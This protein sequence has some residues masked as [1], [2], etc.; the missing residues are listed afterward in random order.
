MSIGLAIISKNEEDNLPTLLASID[1]CFDRVVLLDTGSEDATVPR[2]LAW[3]TDQA[4]DHPGFT[5]SIDSFEWTDDFSEARTAADKLLLGSGGNAVDW[6]C[7]ADCDDTIRGAD[8][9]R[10]IADQAPAEVAALIFGYDYAQDPG[11]G[12]TVCHLR[13]ERL[14]RAGAG[15]WGGRVHEAQTVA[16]GVQLVPD[17]IVQWIHGKQLDAE[18]VGQ[19]NTR[20]LT[21]LSEWVKD[22]PT[23]QRVLAYM[24]KELAARNEHEDALTYYQRYMA[25]PP[26]WSDERAQVYRLY[27]R[28]L[29]AL[30]RPLEE[31]EQLAAEALMFHPM[32]PDSWLTLAEIALAREQHDKGQ[33]YAE[34]VIGQ[35]GVALRSMLIV[36]PLDYTAYPLRLI[37][38][39]HGAAGRTDEAIRYAEQ[40]LSVNPGD[41]F[42]RGWWGAWKAE[43][44]RNHT[45]DT[46]AMCAEQLIAHDEQLKAKTL[47]E[48]CVPYF[49]VDHPRIVQLRQF[50]RRRLS[51]VDD[52]T[53]F[54]DHYE[55]GG[56]KPEDFHSDEQ[57]DE[58]AQALPRTH[59][60]I[61]NLKEQ[62]A[63]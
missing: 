6:T 25:E 3:A 38:A 9:L 54:E 55:T 34:K 59:Y 4:R 62:I 60:L 22:E 47:L 58:I 29:F 32:W 50:L 39:A 12:I 13:R 42:L 17:E 26:G 19:S 20:N 16:G 43:S 56:S 14:V 23:N 11:S 15:T 49:A 30:D 57:S 27:A 44:K 8:Q 48:D 7:W 37:A 51:W 61:E 40:S 53:A 28:S 45:A 33:F 36:N 63:A 10:I 1:G 52:P 18:T 46:Y 31:I 5:Y 35:E 24:A 21:I 2:F 41:E